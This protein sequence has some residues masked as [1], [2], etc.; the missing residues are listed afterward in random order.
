MKTLLFTVAADP[1]KYEK[2]L[3]ETIL[4]QV[5]FVPFQSNEVIECDCVAGIDIP[6]SYS[7]KPSPQQFLLKILKGE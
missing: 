6:G 4:G 3:A 5:Q 1:S 2:R 7:S